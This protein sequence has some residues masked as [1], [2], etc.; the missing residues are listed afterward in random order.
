MSCG[1]R[2]VRQRPIGKVRLGQIK[3][4]SEQEDSTEQV[5]E[6]EEED[7]DEEDKPEPG[8]QVFKVTN[9]ERAMQIAA[10]FTKLQQIAEKILRQE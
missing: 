2:G 9:T 1:R 7:P 8:D 6:D 4:A 3:R 10:G 5:E